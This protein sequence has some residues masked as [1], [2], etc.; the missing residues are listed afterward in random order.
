MNTTWIKSKR[1]VGTYWYHVFAASLCNSQ[2]TC[3]LLFIPP[4][5]FCLSLHLSSSLSFV[6]L[7]MSLTPPFLFCVS[8]LLPL[9]SF[10]F[11]FC[12]SLSRFS[13]LPLS[14]SFLFFLQHLFSLFPFCLALFL[15]VFPSAF[16]PFHSLVFFIPV[17]YSAHSRWAVGSHLSQ[18]FSLLGKFYETQQ[19]YVNRRLGVC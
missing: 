19:Y 3:F 7:S 17:S 1:Q 12:R 15:A 6:R 18:K 2:V 11:S 14:L 13:F 8:C 4:F 10:G 16:L 5:F 9:I